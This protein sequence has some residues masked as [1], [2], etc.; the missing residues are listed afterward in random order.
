M[1]FLNREEAGRMLAEELRDRVTREAL[2]LALPRGGVPVGAEVAEALGLELDVFV[3]RKLGAPMEP[4]LGMGAIAEGGV[5]WVD[6]SL[7]RSLGV[8]PEQLDA[9]ADREAREV[10]RRARLYRRGRPLTDISDRTVVLVDDGIATGGTVRAAVRALRSLGPRRLVLAVPVAAATT[11]EALREEVDEAVAL[12]TPF[13][14][15]GIGA[16][17]DDFRQVDDDEVLA[18]LDRVHR[19]HAAPEYR[20]SAAL[21]SNRVVLVHAAG[22][23]LAGDLDVPDGAAG[24]VVFAHGSGSSRHSARNRAVAE[25]LRAAGCATL[26]FDLLT[27]EEEQEDRLTSALRFDIP[28]LAR[29]LVGA[30]EW[31]RSLPDVGRLPVGLFG[32]STGAAAAL[33]AAA[34]HP[35][36]VSAVVSRGGRPDLAG[37]SLAAVRAPT[38]LIVGGADETVLQLNEK[39]YEALTCEK[40]LSIVPGATHLFEEPGALDDVARRAARWFLTHFQAPMTTSPETASWPGGP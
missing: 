9:I 30:L 19:A 21:G 37:P 2:V 6:R 18:A 7:M 1:R 13:D 35:E 25:R 3:S 40:S 14:L 15:G 29:R 23:R 5:M 33:I 22:V 10:Q 20:R 28:L 12:L 36:H 16:W 27:D 38:L 11:L 4:E 26:L 31:L 39:S 32:A 24:L 8:G 17:Y 34:R